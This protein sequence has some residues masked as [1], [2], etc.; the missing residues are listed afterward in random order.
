MFETNMNEEKQSN[1][2]RPWLGWRKVVACFL[3]LV[4]V[5]FLAFF[6]LTLA[7]K[8]AARMSEICIFALILSG[9]A[10]LAGIV[11][12][13]FIQWL[14]SWRNLRRTL[15]GLAVLA[16]L[17]A[18]FYA[19]ENW[20]GKRAWKNLKRD[21]EAKGEV[22]DWNAYIPPPIPDEQNILKAP[23]MQEWFVGRNATN[24]PHFF[25]W[26]YQ[27]NVNLIPLAELNVVSAKTGFDVSDKTNALLQLDD[28]V[29]RARAKELI[30]AVVGPAVSSSTYA[31]FVAKTFDQIKTVRLSLATD[32]L[33]TTNEVALLF[34]DDCIAPPQPWGRF[35]NRRLLRVEAAGTNSFRLLL[36]AS[37]VENAADWLRRSDASAPEFSLVR[38]AFERSQI[39]LTGDYHR[40]FEM[41]IIN[42]V[43]IRI[44]A[45]AAAQ[46]A[47]CCLVLGR[48]E[49][50]FQELSLIFDMRRLSAAKPTLLVSAMIDV[51]ICGLYVE[52]IADGFRLQAWREPELIALQKQLQNINLP[53]RVADAFRSERAAVC[54]TFQVVS[55]KDWVESYDFAGGL[56]KDLWKRLTDPVYLLLKVAPRGW[57]YQNLVTVA[58]LEAA[59]IESLS[60]RTQLIDPSKSA[61]AYHEVEKAIDR[62]NPFNI[63]ARIAI[64]NFGRAIQTTAQNQTK[65]NQAL[66]VC[67]LERYRL[68][69]GN[70]PEALDALVPLFV[71]KLPPDIIGGQPLKYRRTADGKFLLYSIGWNEKDDGGQVVH[72]KDGSVVNDD[73]VWG[74]PSR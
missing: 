37:E 51:A 29:A 27:T 25:S 6:G 47:Q 1:W 57:I 53:P 32:R 8:P 56:K 72:N 21:L 46:R 2:K 54:Q 44:L 14:R 4:G 48:S 7:A 64:P 17:I 39:R 40:P 60:T 15:L 38:E 59:T 5:F 30:D 61:S 35:P 70:Y 69:H 41:P 34:P 73:W 24:F 20:R 42:F 49:Q 19:E 71:E 62:S 13:F 58:K 28:P 67:G 26:T 22:L 18:I 11:G 65:A 33:P 23:K 50:A 9:C 45:Q 63:L 74:V 66:I 31:I 55:A 36:K 52:A 10:S 3:L 68:A 12:M 16:T 43:G